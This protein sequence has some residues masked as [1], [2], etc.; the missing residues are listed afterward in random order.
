[1]KHIK[2]LAIVYTDDSGQHMVMMPNGEILPCIT[3]TRVT[4]PHD[5][6]TELMVKCRVNLAK[7]RDDAIRI[8]KTYG[9]NDQI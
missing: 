2:G 3:L 1:M 7:D 8:S 6:P 5:G 4:D 9:N